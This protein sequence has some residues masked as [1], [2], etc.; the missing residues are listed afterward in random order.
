MT[1]LNVR[2]QDT[3]DELPRTPGLIV[4]RADT[5]TFD[6]VHDDGQ[7]ESVPREDAS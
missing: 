1:M 5:D 3:R 4:Y 6:M 2:D 7:W